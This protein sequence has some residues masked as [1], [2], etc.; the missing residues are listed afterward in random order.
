MW[1]RPFVIIVINYI[2][3][4]SWS[5]IFFSPTVKWITSSYI[6]LNLGIRYLPVFT[7]LNFGAS[8]FKLHN[9]PFITCFWSQHQTFLHEFS[10]NFPSTWHH[11]SL[12][13]LP[14]WRQ[15]CDEQGT[16][17]QSGLTTTMFIWMGIAT[18]SILS[19][20]SFVTRI[21]RMVTRKRYYLRDPNRMS[22][23]QNPG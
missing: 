6:L 4:R 10:L 2:P 8:H 22:Q 16:K 7:F 14:S 1:E 3:Y 17:P 23:F 20:L 15:I 5:W 11:C 9:F 13:A 12:V 18:H 19:H 21:S